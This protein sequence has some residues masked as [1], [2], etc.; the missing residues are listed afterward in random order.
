MSVI[1]NIHK[2]LQQDPEI[3]DLFTRKEEYTYS[4]RDQYD[5]FPFSSRKNP[6]IFDPKASWYLVSHGYSVDF[7]NAAPFAVCLTHDIDHVYQPVHKKVLSALGSLKHGNL[8]EALTRITHLSSK[9]LP[10]CNFSAIMDLEE[11]FGA[12]ST[13]FFKADSPGEPDYTYT[14]ADLESEIWEIVDRGWEIGLH[15]GCTTYNNV[16]EMRVKKERLEKITHC[17]VV[18]YRNH[19]LRFRAPDTWELLNQAGFLYDTTLGY[20]ESAGFRNGMCH[21]FKPFNLITN[22][23]IEILE[24]PLIV[25]DTTFN[26][27]YN[28]LDDRA[29]WEIIKMLIDRVASCHGVITVLWHNS[30]MHVEMYKKILTYCHDKRAWMTGGK[31]IADSFNNQ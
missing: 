1:M 19:F 29:T 24:I 2:L 9:K 6:A 18:G 26:P 25:M 23:E 27:P 30:Y 31:E 10:F 17:P 14:C 16:R 21:A 8:T 5:R 20:A 11:K 28:N 12:K 13:F 15:G 22:N 7:P 4:P 3:W